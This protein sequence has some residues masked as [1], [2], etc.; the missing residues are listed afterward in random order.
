MWNRLP[1]PLQHIIQVVVVQIVENPPAA[2]VSSSPARKS[3]EV[4]NHPIDL[5]LNIFARLVP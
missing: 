3:A 4:A 1:L 2:E 5:H